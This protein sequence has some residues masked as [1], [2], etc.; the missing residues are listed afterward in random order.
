[1]K[2][3]C[4]T[5]VAF[6]THS[7]RKAAVSSRVIALSWSPA[8]ITSAER[9]SVRRAPVRGVGEPPAPEQKRRVASEG[10]QSSPITRS[11]T[12]VLAPQRGA[13]VDAA[14]A[15]RRTG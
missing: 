12:L 15:R 10:G 2:G 8:G 3:F 1:M 13:T 5:K 7:S 4:R 14:A 11:W 9:G 6:S